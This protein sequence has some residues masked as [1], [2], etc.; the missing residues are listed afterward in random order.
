[1]IPLEKERGQKAREEER[2][3]KVVSMMRCPRCHGL[4]YFEKFL[5]KLEFFN[6]WRCIN[7]G[8]IVDSVI[9][10]NRDSCEAHKG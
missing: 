4:M 9:M 1:M 6:G 3:R 7:C 2:V 5:N 10:E 8:E